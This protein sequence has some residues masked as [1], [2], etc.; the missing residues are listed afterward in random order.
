MM[1]LAG[2]VRFEKLMV[3]FLSSLSVAVT[4][5]SSSKPGKFWLCPFT[6]HQINF[7]SCARQENIAVCPWA[8]STAV[9]GC[10]YFAVDPVSE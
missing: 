9:G 3:E 5:S 2:I 7:A 8:A 6:V 4:A 10:R 1:S